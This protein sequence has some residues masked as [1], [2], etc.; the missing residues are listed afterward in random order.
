MD[1]RNS[2]L[3]TWELNEIYSTMDSII[4]LLKSDE[5]GAGS[6]LLK[7]MK[8]AQDHIACVENRINVIDG[9]NDPEFGDCDYCGNAL[10]NSL[11]Y[12]TFDN[13]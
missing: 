12:S 6:D 1:S 5:T 13:S 3:V 4:R 10:I 11:V 7:H 8:L 9:N 2:E